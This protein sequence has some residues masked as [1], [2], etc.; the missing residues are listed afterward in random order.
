MSETRYGRSGLG[1]ATPS[2]SELDPG[3]GE[4]HVNCGEPQAGVN[5]GQAALDI[6]LEIKNIWAQVYSVLNLNHALLEVGEYEQALRVT[7]QGVEMARTLPNP[8]LLFFLL[9]VLGVVHQ[10]M[11]SLEEAHEA[12]IEAL[13]LG[14]SIAVRL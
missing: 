14:E 10:A 7:Q 6:G 2:T 3:S 11:L 4:G 8:T 13:A 1:R 9:T 12:L 5:A